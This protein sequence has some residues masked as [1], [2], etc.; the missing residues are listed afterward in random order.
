[1]TG[2][3]V[4]EE[5][6]IEGLRAVFLEFTREVYRELPAFDRPRILDV[7]CGTGTGPEDRKELTRLEREV[8]A[9]KADIS[10]TDCS[11]V[12]VAMGNV[13]RGDPVPQA[14]KRSTPMSN[15]AAQTGPGAMVLVAIEQACPEGERL[16]TDPPARTIVPLVSRFWVRVSRPVKSFIIRETEQVDRALGRHLGPQ[17]LHRQCARRLPGRR[18]RHHSRLRETAAHSHRPRLRPR[19][20][21]ATRRARGRRQL[22]PG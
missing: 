19:P 5:L 17:A 13:G 9:V 3:N 2:R 11:F 12:I 14:R 4:L 6:G 20:L 18:L 15:K 22:R 10:K 21:P 1:M 16:I 7:G 8:E